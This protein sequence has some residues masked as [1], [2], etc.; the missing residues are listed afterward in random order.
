MS[1][2]QDCSMAL[3]VVGA[4]GTDSLS[5]ILSSFFLL[6]FAGKGSPLAGALIFDILLL[7]RRPGDPMRCFLLR[8]AGATSLGIMIFLPGAV[9]GLSV[10]L[11][12]MLWQ[13]RPHALWQIRDLLIRHVVPLFSCALFYSPTHEPL[14][15]CS[16]SLSL[17]HFICPC[18]SPRKNGVTSCK[19][20]IGFVALSYQEALL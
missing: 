17:P 15:F 10:D 20:G 5:L 14:D 3:L 4:T 1:I 9:K 18:M 6:L 8:L 2:R 12:R 16:I 19:I 11:S 13:M 7:H